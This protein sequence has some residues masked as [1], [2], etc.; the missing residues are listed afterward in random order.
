[1]SLTSSLYAGTSGLGNTGRALQVTSNNI[2]NMNTLGF[3]KGTANFADT[4]YRQIGTNAGTS[5]VGLGMN[6]DNVSQVFTDGSLEVTSNSTD[7]AIG[8]EGFFIV[9]EHGSEESYYTRAGNFSFDEAGALVSSEGYIV[10]GWAVDGDTGEE[11]GGITDLILT[12]FTSPPDDTEEI[13]L[14][15]N[16]DADAE[17]L[18]AVLSNV[19][20]HDEEDGTTMNAGGYEYQNVI[21]VYDSLGSSHEV[22]VYYDKKST[23]EWEYVIACSPDEDKRALTANTDAAGLLARGTITFGPGSGNIVDMTMEEFTGLVGNV[24]LSGGNNSVQDVHF[25]IED[26]E[27]IDLDGYGFEVS[28]NG[29]DWDLTGEGLGAGNGLPDNYLLATITDSSATDIEIDLDGDGETDLKVFLDQYPVTGEILSFDVNDPTEVHI[30][31]IE[32][33]VYTGGAYNNT[34]LSINDASVM[35]TPVQGVSISYTA[36]TDTWAWVGAVPAEYPNATLSGDDTRCYIDL[37]GSGTEDDKEDIVFTFTDDL[38]ADATITFDI[39]GSTAWREITDEEKKN[40][41]YCQF[42]V[43]FLGGEQGTTET[44]ILF[45]IGSKFDGNN[46][47]ND[48]LSS[49]QYASSSST[50][51]Q[52]ADGYATGDLVGIE[53]EGDGLV[54][55]TYSNGEK[56]DLFKVAL[57]DFNNVGGLESVG[58]NLY[59]ATTDSGSAITNKPGEN[60]LGTLSSYSLEMSNV[61]ISEEFVEMIELQTAYEANA[62][63]ISTVDEMMTTVVS[64]KR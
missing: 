37:D 43:D 12:A 25:A 20:A 5:Q 2:S 13:T 62:K 59:T 54:S 9:S 17:S 8:G 36:V 49:T 27:A 48:S 42:M 24:D 41:E 40:G 7:L 56:I 6:V 4:I 22:T 64:M 28:Y 33:A 14:I 16:L 30:Q 11:Y 45:N 21:T 19:F 10:Q 51:Y 35:T 58:G 15:T 63:I 3:K 18:S 31:D 26:A 52:D 32:N 39:S 23:T 61:D 29:T 57:A 55:G 47:I 60:G 46:W 44:N 38:S 34:T 53:V 1:M 50:I